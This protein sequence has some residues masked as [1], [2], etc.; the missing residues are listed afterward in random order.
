MLRE[1][2]HPWVLTLFVVVAVEQRR[3]S[4]RWL[5]NRWTHGILALRA[6]EVLLVAMLPTVITRHRFYLHQFRA[7]DLVAAASMVTF[8]ALLGALVWRE[9]A[10]SSAS[11][12]QR[13]ETPS[14]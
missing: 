6:V 3:S 13:E 5:R 12:G 7:T 10:P 8:C 14:A 9:R 4:F 1:G 11:L 2:L